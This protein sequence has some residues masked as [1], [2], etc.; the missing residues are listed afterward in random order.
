MQMDQPIRGILFDLGDTLLDFGKI[1]APRLF[2]AGGKL[3]Y[4]YLRRL[5]QPLPP[6]WRYYR[7][8]LLSIRWNYLRSRLTGREFNSLDLMKRIAREFGQQLTPEQFAELAWLWYRPLGRCAR[9]EEGLHEMLARLRE[10]G[11]TLGVVSNT[12]L[13]APVLDRHL[14]QVEL[15]EHLPVRVYSSDVGYRKPRREIFQE[16][17]RQAELTPGETVFVGDSPRADIHGARRMGM[18][19]ILKDPAD[20][21]H[22]RGHRADRRIRSILELPRVLDELSTNG[23]G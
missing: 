4:A 5:K 1:N 23:R 14:G 12:F 3:A 9:V 15:L 17:F 21:Y 13:P 2:E 19:T 7:H 6:F 11:L 22:R 8:Q 18:R 20:R 16:A 10:T